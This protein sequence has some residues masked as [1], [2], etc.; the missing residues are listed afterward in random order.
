MVL[1]WEMN[2]NLP[3]MNVILLLQLQVL[4][5]TV[6]GTAPTILPIHLAN[7][8]MKELS[9]KGHVHG[10]YTGLE[11]LLSV[12]ANGVIVFATVLL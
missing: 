10:S 8:H 7:T 4:P 3:V 11:K 2:V 9:S 12:E 1:V 5:L 6:M